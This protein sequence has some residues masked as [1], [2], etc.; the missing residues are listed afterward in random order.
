MDG[1]T[2]VEFYKLNVFEIHETE[3]F[4]ARIAPNV[5]VNTASLQS[6]HVILQLPPDIWARLHSARLGPWLPVHLGPAYCLMSAVKESG[7]DTRLINMAFPDATNV[8]LTKV[9]LGPD[10]GAGNV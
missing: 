9:G 4:L 8:A 1:V 5:I 6:W 2:K 7:I 10:L 3:K